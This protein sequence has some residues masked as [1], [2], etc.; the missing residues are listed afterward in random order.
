MTRGLPKRGMPLSLRIL[1]WCLL[2]LLLLAVLFWG[3][4]RGQLGLGLDSLLTGRAGDRLQ[5]MADVLSG[6]LSHMNEYEWDGVISR[7]SSAYGVRLA[8]VKLDGRWWA[9]EK[10][11]L[12]EEV[13]KRLAEPRFGNRPGENRAGDFR[14]GGER[15]G[16]PPDGLPPELRGPPRAGGPEGRRF[17]GPPNGG[18][19][20]RGGPPN[21][22]PP[23]GSFDE[24]LENFMERDNGRTGPPG[25]PPGP[26]EPR[27]DAGALT[28]PPP[29]RD[30]DR[31]LLEAGPPNPRFPPP[32]ARPRFLVRAGEPALYWAGVPMPA[33]RGDNGRPA[34]AVLL[35]VAENLTESGWVIDPAPWL[36]AGFG[37]VLLSLLLWFPLVRGITR[38]IRAMT[39]A[40]ER[41]A[42]GKFDTV[43]EVKRTDELGRLA[44]TINHLA[45]RLEHFVNGQRRFL[46]DIAHELNSPLARMQLGTSLLE[47]GGDAA[48]QERVA[49][50]R[51]EVEV[52]INLVNELLSFSKAGLRARDVPLEAVPLAGMVRHVIVREAGG[53]ADAVLTEIP[54]TLTAM[55]DPE[56]LSRA[57]A[58]LVRNALR[59]AGYAGPVK[60]SA[61]TGHGDVFLT[62]SDSG[63]GV[64]EPEL[65]RIF[66]PFHRPDT[67]RTREAGGSGLGLAI[68]RSCVQACQGSV[69][70][71]N[72]APSGLAVTIRLAAVPGSV[73][74]EEKAEAV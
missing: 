17:R 69:S 22:G 47:R 74:P 15:S 41:I 30:Q 42:E 48:H 62:V 51:E 18:G 39:A 14:P 50:V 60:I 7:T 63:P 49:D 10:L 59:Y 70:A 40:T 54:E 4:F 20:P 21:G 9:G 66:E 73:R 13:R 27:G 34:P 44:R 57:V 56:L 28:E 72:R 45:G 24:F 58:N 12:P 52:M 65:E 5:S 38:S 61:G 53:G 2:N 31:P 71:S 8:L 23:R 36:M 26:P 68:V 43:A 35:A 32:V 19:Q 3:L 64:P 11:E 16:G 37:A 46:G 29:G 25:P 55:A 1:L 6:E 33:V 67:A